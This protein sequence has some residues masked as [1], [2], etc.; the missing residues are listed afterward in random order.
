MNNPSARPA[1]PELCVC[2][3]APAA[4]CLSGSIELHTCEWHRL[5]P[6]DRGRNASVAR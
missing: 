2:I 6:T 5:G 3:A 1:F 4:G